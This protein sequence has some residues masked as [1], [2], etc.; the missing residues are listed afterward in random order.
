[1]R[2]LY[3]KNG[4]LT[5][6]PSNVT[7]E[8][9]LTISVASPPPPPPPPPLEVAIDVDPASTDNVVNL[10]TKKPKPLDVAVFGSLDFDVLDVRPETMV[11]G[12]PILTDPD[13][14]S[15][16][17]VTPTAIAVADLDGDGYLDLSLQFDLSEMQAAG[18]IDELSQS[19]QFLAT[20]DNEGLVYGSDAVKTSGGKGKGRK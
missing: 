4:G 6:Q 19:L 11:L 8:I 17:K 14:G 15:G 13:T 12:D 18:A 10:K 5:W 7:P 2:S 3:S 20:L 1:M 9:G 16:L